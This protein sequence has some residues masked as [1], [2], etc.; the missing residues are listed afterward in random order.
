MTPGFDDSGTDWKTG[1][2]LFGND[3]A[4]V[5]N[6]VN[7]P[8][9]GGINGFATPLSRTGNRVTFYFRTHFNLDDVPV[10]GA[11]LY[12][13]NYLDDGAVFYINGTEVGRLRVPAGALTWD[14][15]GSNPATEGAPTRIDMPASALV[16]GDNVLAV[17]V[18]QSGATSSDVAFAMNLIL[19]NPFSPVILNNNLPADVSV[20]ENRPF[21]LRCVADASPP[22]AFQWVKD[23]VD[24]TGANS[25]TYTVARATAADIGGYYCRVSNP[26]G[27]TNSRTATVAVTEDETSPEMIGAIAGDFVS[28]TVQFDETMDPLTSLDDFNWALLDGNGDPVALEPGVLAESVNGTVVTLRL[29]AGTTLLENALYTVNSAGGLLDLAGNDLGEANVTFRTFTSAGCSGF[30]FEAFDTASTPGNAISLLTSHPNYPNNPRDVARMPSLDSRHAYVDNAHEQFG[31][32]VRGLYVPLISGPHT[33]YLASDDAGQLWVNPTG[34]DSAGRQMVAQELNCCN[35]FQPTGDPKTSVPINLTAGQA[36]Y[37]EAL[38]KEG[39]GG[40]WLKV[41]ARPSSDPVPPGGNA[42]NASV[43]PNVIQGGAGPVGVLAHIT[44][45]S[46]PADTTVIAGQT[47]QFSTTLSA[48]VP[49]CFQWRKDGVDIS[50]AIGRNYGFTTSLADDNTRYS[51]RVSLMGGTILDSTA[52][53]LRVSNDVTPP[54][55]VSA[56]TDPYGTNVT[57]V[58]S[59]VMN[60]ASVGNAANYQVNGGAVTI[61][62]VTVSSPTTVILAVSPALAGCVTHTVRISAVQDQFLNVISPN[63]TTLSFLA[64]LL[65]VPLDAVKLW[66]YEDTGANLG[67]AWRASGYDD[68]AWP[69]GPGVLAFETAAIAAPIRTVIRDPRTT[70]TPGSAAYFRTHFDLPTDP[71]TVTSF[72][73]RYVVDDGMVIYLN[74]TELYRQAV[75]TGETFDTFSTRT[76]GDATVFEGPFDLPTSALVA[77]DNVIAVSAHQVNAGSSDN[78]MGLE[79]TATASSCGVR[80]R[81]SISR[82]GNQVTITS[83][84]PGGTI[85]RAP[86]VTGPWT[87]VGAAPQTVT[88]GADS[89]FTIRP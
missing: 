69:Q 52:A 5:Y 76:V 16:E 81:L 46:H 15:V 13:T 44:I 75:P 11:S 83:T 37:V 2:A 10:A 89:F 29:A 34:P 20:I 28:V 73:V 71:S 79:L 51:V 31:A 87:P 61:N 6:S 4:G 35:D 42:D 14:T 74:G 19:I 45:A 47:A 24:I 70:P 78:V 7:H 77:G 32:R 67:T 62:A 80:P 63:P 56:S 64:P 36:Y 40:D 22:I 27:S 26:V 21:T 17:E 55:A 82:S 84:A 85:H 39:T 50:G 53:L 86:S 1:R 3:D 23:D 72:R 49:A 12:S 48:D 65:L 88:I 30:L 68:S 18:H 43:S 57:V 58:F 9:T 66:R 25:P 33:F 59:E 41:A 38:F 54:T 60:A 8:F